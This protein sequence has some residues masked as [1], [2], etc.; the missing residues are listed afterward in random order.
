MFKALDH[1]G[2]TR[3][4]YVRA[5]FSYP[6]G[7]F[8]SIPNILPHLPYTDRYGE[9]FGGTGAILLA[10]NQSKLEVYNDRYG[11]VTCFYRILRDR[12]KYNELVE[13]L[14]FT[15]CSR[16][17][18]IW[19]R[20]SWKNCEDE[21]ERAARWFYTVKV[22]FGSQARNFGRS[23]NPKMSFSTLL[24]NSLSLFHALHRRIR[25]VY[26][27]NLDWKQCVLDYDHEDMVWYLDPEYPNTTPGMFEY[28]S[29]SP[30][31]H[32]SILKW[33][34]TES[35]G[36]VAISSYP[37][38]MYESKKWTKRIEWPAYVSTLS[39]S[40]EETN[41][42]QGHEHLRRKHATEVLYIK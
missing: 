36:F 28:S 29:N 35:K 23:K 37:N 18:F 33:I 24:P 25:A 14:K 22:S 34:F 27:E 17:E 1:E 30:E 4:Y 10:R 20:D 11:G 2:E 13:R 15:L 9:P 8:R 32:E 5:P 6:G 39:Q 38:P 26:I 19:S 31:F 12:S 41:H 7:K 16:E 3:E 21:I 40:F 42:L